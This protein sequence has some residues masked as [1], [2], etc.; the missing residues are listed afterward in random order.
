MV[1]E[2]KTNNL[3]PRVIATQRSGASNWKKPSPMSM[4]FAGH[5]QSVPSPTT[6]TCNSAAESF[7]YFQIALP[8]KWLCAWFVALPLDWFWLKKVCLMD[9]APALT[10]YRQTNQ[11]FASKYMWWFFLIQAAK[12]TT[13]RA[14]RSW[15]RF[16]PSGGQKTQ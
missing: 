14:T 15:H 13:V 16:T 8:Q 9:I 1:F 10:M 2:H 5:E 4:A 7:S 3:E 6:R 11:E 12:R